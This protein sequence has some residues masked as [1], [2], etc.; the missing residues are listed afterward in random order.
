MKIL[1]LWGEKWELDLRT[2]KFKGDRILSACTQNAVLRYFSDRTLL[3]GK[4]HVCGHAGFNPFG[5]I[6]ELEPDGVDGRLAG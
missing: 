5:G 4:G 2:S 3:D 6:I 1:P